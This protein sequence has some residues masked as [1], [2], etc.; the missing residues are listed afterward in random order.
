MKPY[1]NSI[2]VSALIMRFFIGAV[3][4]YAGILKLLDPSAFAWNIY[5]YGLVPRSA[6]AVMA[7]GLPILEVLAGIGFI[8]NIRGSLLAIAGMLVLFLFVLG[9][10]MINGLNVDCGCFSVG[11]PGPEG[12]RNAFIRD[13]LMMAGVGFV[14]ASRHKA[15][16]WNF[17]KRESLH[18]EEDM[19]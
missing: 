9:Y 5:Q 1:R 3:F 19:Q 17:Q 10:A 18:I 15:G 16:D 11:E 7:V 4:V 13:I 14:H 12:L 6:I 2:Q 8:F